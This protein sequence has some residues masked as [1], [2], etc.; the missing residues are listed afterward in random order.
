MQRSTLLIGLAALV[1]AGLIVWLS[2]PGRPL[3]PTLPEIGPG[4][5]PIGGR[6]GLGA[7]DAG[8]D[9]RD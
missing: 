9:H 8:R 2:M 3:Q 5:R 4:A 6:A 7:I 1:A